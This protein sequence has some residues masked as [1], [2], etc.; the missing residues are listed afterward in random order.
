M[1]D[2]NFSLHYRW[3]YRGQGIWENRDSDYEGRWSEERET[4]QHRLSMERDRAALGS[5]VNSSFTRKM[6]ANTGPGGASTATAG[7]REKI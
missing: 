5:S 3:E 7:H 2:F 6:S 4:G 1:R